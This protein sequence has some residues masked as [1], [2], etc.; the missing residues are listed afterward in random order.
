MSQGICFYSQYS[1][2][3][4]LL[5]VCL[6]SLE[7]NYSG[8]IHVVMGNETPKWFV[9]LAKNNKRIST[10]M[11][12]AMNKIEGERVSQNCWNTKPLIHKLLPFD[13]NL[14]YDCDSV[15]VNKFDSSIFEMVKDRKLASFN[16]KKE[17]L[18]AKSIRQGIRRARSINFS[19]GEN[20]GFL[21]S[22]N[23]GCVGSLKKG[24]SPLINEWTENINKIIFSEAKYLQR[25]PDEYG[26]SLVMVKHKI[27][28]DGGKWSYVPILKSQEDVERE[29]KNIISLHF[30]HRKYLYSRHYYNAL[31]LALNEDYMGLA[32]L[33][34]KY[35]ICNKPFS[36]SLRKLSRSLKNIVK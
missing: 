7:R 36:R 33:S 2:P 28:V 15:F 29:L 31:N 12:S 4:P 11:T 16:H 26:L 20:I 22:I 17:E 23:G 10:S 34:R 9:E 19:L 32:S 27:P 8:D 14:L 5:A 24:S 30:A 18:T 6:H 21:P 3:L 25:V 35:R 1:Y 13:I